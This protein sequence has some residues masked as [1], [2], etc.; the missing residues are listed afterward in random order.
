MLQLKV[1]DV[2]FRIATISLLLEPYHFTVSFFC[3]GH[4]NIICF[5]ISLS[6]K[7]P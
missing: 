5:E 3:I 4:Y 1:V 2:A 7:F 6:I